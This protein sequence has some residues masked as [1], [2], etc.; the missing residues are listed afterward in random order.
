[1]HLTINRIIYPV[2]NLG[3]GCR[4][5]I[6]LQG[7]QIGCAGCIN[8][9]LHNPDGGRRV[10]ISSL[11]N[12]LSELVNSMDGI[13]IT[14]GEPF[15]QYRELMAFCAF[16]KKKT[17]KPVYVYSGYTLDELMAR[18]PDKFFLTVIDLLNA[19]PYISDLN[20]NEHY[21]GSSNQKLYSFEANGDALNREITIKTMPFTHAI[22]KWSV[23]MGKKS[24][25]FL[26]GIPG[27]GD[28]QTMKQKMYQSG[29]KSDF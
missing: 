6:W 24:G 21:R 20:K 8:P 15:D 22:A 25:L 13:T 4:V 19:G 5:A 27:K 26:T 17:G 3:P 11:V 18:F 16:F 23:G 9:E 7:C 29:I 12:T 14:G 28:I 2:Y 10:E 1:M